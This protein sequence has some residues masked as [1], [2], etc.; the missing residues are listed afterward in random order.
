MCL[1]LVWHQ[2]GEHLPE[3]DRLLAELGPRRRAVA[4]VEDQVDHGEHGAQ[5]LRE[6]VVGR[7]AQRNRGV[8]DLPLGPHE[9]LGHR[10]LGDE[11][12]AGD[13]FRG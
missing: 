8:P 11:E 6:Q 13:L 10:R 3:P 9:P 5:A 2:H 12:G 1:G 7:D 4:L